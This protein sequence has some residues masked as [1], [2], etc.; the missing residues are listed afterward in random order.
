[1]DISELDT[2]WYC[3]MWYPDKID[4]VHSSKEVASH[5]LVVS[6]SVQGEPQLLQKIVTTV[7]SGLVTILV[8]GV[9]VRHK[10]VVE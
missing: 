2:N 1:M 6:S 3:S 5:Q 7:A 9:Q 4:A 8:Q 10:R